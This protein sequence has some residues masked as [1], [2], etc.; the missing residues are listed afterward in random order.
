VLA[1]PCYCEHQTLSTL[2]AILPHIHV[3]HAVQQLTNPTQ[4][5][6]LDKCCSSNAPRLQRVVE[7]VR[8]ALA[9]QRRRARRRLA[10]RRGRAAVEV[11]SGRVEAP[12]LALTVLGG[13][14]AR[15]RPRHL[16]LTADRDLCGA[17]DGRQAVSV[18]EM[19]KAPT[20]TWCTAA[21]DLQIMIMRALRGVLNQ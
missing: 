10:R 20:A 11:R 4:S 6:A 8:V 14:E 2:L 15:V 1:A 18:V 13:D 16:R 12:A 5:K 19:L 9:M 17:T 21:D 7:P 3:Q